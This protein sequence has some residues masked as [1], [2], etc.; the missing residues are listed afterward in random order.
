MQLSDSKQEVTVDFSAMICVLPSPA[1]VL[2]VSGPIRTHEQICLH[3]ETF[4]CSEMEYHRR[5]FESDD[6]THFVGG[7]QPRRTVSNLGESFPLRRGQLSG[8]TCLNTILTSNPR[9]QAHILLPSLRTSY[10][11]E[12]ASDLFKHNGDNP[13]AG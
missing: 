3:F 8:L 1:D 7:W 12:P 4:T 10:L 5:G 13:T 9:Y 11:H 6:I 2:L